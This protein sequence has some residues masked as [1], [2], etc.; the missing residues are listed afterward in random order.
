MKLA[1][2]SAAWFVGTAVFAADAPSSDWAA[3]VKLPASE[4]A[5]ALFNG[6]DLT[7]WKGNSPYWS[8]EGGAIVGKNSAENAPKASTYLISERKPRA[9]RLLFEGKLVTSEMHS[10]VALWGTPIEKEGDPHS[11][12]GHLV[13]FPSKWGFWDLYRRNSI[14]KDDGRAVKAGRQHDWNQI[15]VLAQ[16]PR[17]RVAV[18]G[19]LIADWTDPKPELCGEGPLGLQLHSNKVAQEVHFRGLILSENPEDKLVTITADASPK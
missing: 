3:S 12:T 19:Q 17:I 11:Y 4:K 5:V 14:Y 9:F 8:V 1:L 15:E 10:G 2:L 13:M 7:G 16:P 6:K 18:N